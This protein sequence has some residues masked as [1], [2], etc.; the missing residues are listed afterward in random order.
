MCIGTLYPLS[1]PA[2]DRGDSLI[3]IG[4]RH[5]VASDVLDEEREI[6]VS[7]PH[8]YRTSSENRYPV[9]YVL[10]AGSE[11]HHSVTSVRYLAENANSIPDFVVVG[12]RLSQSG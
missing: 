10:D 6:L 3:S 5:H 1:S 11:F 8:D 12:I 9:L 7:L 4:M 2:A